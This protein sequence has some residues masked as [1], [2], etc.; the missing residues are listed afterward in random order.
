MGFLDHFKPQPR[1]KHADSAVRAAAVEALPDEEQDLL[2]SIALEDPEAAVRR[3]AVARLSDVEVLARIACEDAHE[4]VRAEARELVLG[5]A[6][7]ATDPTEAGRALA[8]LTDSRELAIVARSAELPEIAEAALARITD[9]RVV[10]VVARQAGH[11]AVRMAA[12]ARLDAP[13]DL[14]AVAIKSEHRDVTTAAVDRL[15]SREHL[16]LVVTRARQKAASRRAR[17]LLRVMEEAERVPQQRAARRTQICEAAEGLYQAPSLD[18]AAV[19]LATLEAEWQ[20]LSAEA[21]EVQ[22]QRFAAAKDRLTELLAR[23]AAER[24]EHERTAQALAEEIASGLAARDAVCARV[25]ALDGPEAAGALDEARTVW[26]A[27]AP[28]PEAGRETPAVRAV[29]ARFAR[30]VAECE[31]RLAR[32][33]AIDARRGEAETLVAQAETA[34]ALPEFGAARSALQPLRPAWQTL[35]AEGLVTEDLSARMQAVEA[36]FARRDAEA[37][38][39]RARQVAENLVRLEHLAHRLEAL[40]GSEHVNLRD[41]ERGVREARAVID[42]T[43]PLPAKA[44]HDRLVRQLKDLTARLAPKL[45]EGRESEEWRRWANAGVQEDL[46]RRAEALA[47]IENQAEAAKALRDLQAEW[48]KVSAVPRDQADDLRQRFTTACDQARARLNTFFAAQREQETA[49]LQQKIALCERAEA[50]AD[51]TDWIRTAEEMK[52]LQAEWQKVGPVPHDQAK[53]TWNRFRGACDRFFT[54]RKDDLGQRKKMWAENLVRKEAICA[55]VEE[56]AVST[57][58][59]ATAA[60]IKRLQAEWKAIGPVK[61]SRSEAIWQ[62]FRAGCDTFF[63]RYKNRDQVVLSASAGVREDLLHELETLAGVVPRAVSAAEPASATAEPAPGDADAGPPAAREAA[64][65]PPAELQRRVLDV[66]QRWQHSPRLPWSVAEP[67]ERRF[68]QALLAVIAASP[69]TFKGTRLD[70]EANLR[71]M[72]DLCLQVEVLAG[73]RPVTASDLAAAPPET[74]AS[75]LK[76]RL[77]ANTLGGRADEESRRRAAAVTVKDAQAAWRRLGPVPGDRARQ[78]QARFLRACRR[79]FDADAATPAPGR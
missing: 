32:Q 9:A 54:R 15:A 16:D 53:T 46:C 33:A 34:V 37:R 10:S 6:R 25:E 49:N 43:G 3:T 69:E 42:H 18:A 24:A 11:A 76:D 47:Q 39:Q 63:E 14:L 62:R 22:R 75:M 30:A 13:D 5:V 59:N 29:E 65:P 58:W 71:R 73:G 70:V 55:R 4:S 26:V 19:Q 17:T 20:D 44:D 52:R 57:D 35:A 21:D 27:L 72:D 60:E 74:L 8:G 67:L 40:A 68:E 38:E 41:L 28:W 56:L 23:S 66:W 51:S 61:P 45:Q 78:L 2:R 12:L 77:A 79:F 50:L 64:P 1:W 48:R 36:A 7:D 31:R